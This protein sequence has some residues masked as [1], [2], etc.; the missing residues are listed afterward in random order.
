MLGRALNTGYLLSACLEVALDTGHSNAIPT[1]TV[2]DAD[3]TSK[4]EHAQ[5][6]V[7]QNTPISPGELPEGLAPAIPDWYKVGWRQVG[8]IDA[9]PPT[10]GEHKDKLVLDMFLGEQFYGTWYHNA[11]I[12]VFVCSPSICS[13]STTDCFYPRRL[14]LRHISLPGLTLVGDGYSS[15]S[16]YAVLITLHPLSASDAGHVTISSENSSRLVLPQYMNP[17]TG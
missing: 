1:I 14:Y 4:E 3:A 11:A 16:P 7:T 6:V 2:S 10:A 8:G 17:Q 12:I 13:K 9:D 5:E 15:S